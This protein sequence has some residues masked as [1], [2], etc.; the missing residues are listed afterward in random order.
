V[1]TVDG[2]KLT[3]SGIGAYHPALFAG[4]RRGDKARLAALLAAPMAAGRVSGE[5]FRGE[6]NDV[7]TPQRLAELDSRLG[8]ARAR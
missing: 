8:T 7:G 5:H 6:W 3:F 4:V 1:V 2:D